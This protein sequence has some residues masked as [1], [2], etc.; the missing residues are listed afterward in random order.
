[1]KSIERKDSKLGFKLCSSSFPSAHSKT[2]SSSSEMDSN[3]RRMEAVAN[4]LSGKRKGIQ[5][6]P[7]THKRTKGFEDTVLNFRAY[8]ID[9]WL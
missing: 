7:P 1:M 5:T 2:R 4:M 9:N 6:Q 3:Q 8:S